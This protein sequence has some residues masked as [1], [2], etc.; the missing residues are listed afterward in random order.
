MAS[1]DF[2]LS[3]TWNEPQIPAGVPKPDYYKGGIPRKE[4]E[5]K[6]QSM[7]GSLRV[8]VCVCDYL[9]PDVKDKLHLGVTF[10]RVLQ[11]MLRAVCEQCLF[12][13]L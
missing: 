11:H 2:N 7:G 4:I 5:S 6:Q 10:L 8:C 3:R 1:F 9:M 12:V 13:L